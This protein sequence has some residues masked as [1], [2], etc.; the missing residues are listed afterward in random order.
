[1]RGCVGQPLFAGEEVSAFPKTPSPQEKKGP[2]RHANTRNKA[3]G[4]RKT[5]DDFNVR[6]LDMTKKA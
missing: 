3:V 2:K 1:V 6:Q 5:E 4:S